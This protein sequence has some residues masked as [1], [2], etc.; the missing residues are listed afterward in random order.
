M[1]TIY[2][3]HHALPN[4]RRSRIMHNHAGPQP[5]G[6]P[7]TGAPPPPP[8]PIIA[9]PPKPKCLPPYSGVDKS[10]LTHYAEYT[11]P[12]FTTLAKPLRR[13]AFAFQT[14]LLDQTTRK[15]DRDVLDVLRLR[16][17]ANNLTS[18]RPDP[19]T[20]AADLQA[21]RRTIRGKGGLGVY[22]ILGARRYPGFAGLAE[23]LLRV[24][25]VKG[26]LER[27]EVGRAWRVV[28]RGYERSERREERTGGQGVGGGCAGD[29]MAGVG[30]DGGL[31]I[32]N[33]GLSGQFGGPPGVQGV[34]VGG[35]NDVTGLDAG[36]EVLASNGG[37][38]TQ[39][40]GQP[41]GQGMNGGLGNVVNG[42][43]TP[44]E[45]MHDQLS[46][47]PVGP[48]SSMPLMSHM[49][50][51]PMYNGGMFDQSNGHPVAQGMG[52]PFGDGMNGYLTPA[53]EA[54]GQMD[55]Q[56]VAPGMATFL[57]SQYPTANGGVV[58]QPGQQSVVSGM[59]A[60]SESHNPMAN[61]GMV[62][63]PERQSVGLDAPLFAGIEDPA[64]DGN[65]A[66]PPS[67]QPFDQGMVA[68][69]GNDMSDP[70]GTSNTGM[71]NLV[72]GQ[73][74]G[75]GAD[76]L[77]YDNT[78]VEEQLPS[79]MMA[80][81]PDFE[82]FACTDYSAYAGSQEVASAATEPAVQEA[83]EEEKAES[84]DLDGMDFEQLMDQRAVL[85]RWGPLQGSIV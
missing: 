49:N 82:T 17:V 11:E 25:V 34:G 73:P 29:W 53:A 2:P 50:G 80:G 40:N 76:F 72:D 58:M 47:Q 57:G 68:S 51:A 70:N 75:P 26:R 30:L 67:Q 27:G 8:P 74:V 19:E 31:L 84:D 12:E 35:G 20:G 81:Q 62:M 55:G 37:M 33:E 21:Y 16:D 39:P 18:V 79:E 5:I 61:S 45:D 28:R 4:I 60:S 22:L 23:E 44:E 56:P 15:N 13:K 83:G 6:Y 71:P 32:G 14:N 9:I 7:I 42:L 63:L 78:Q 1:A 69:A 59:A 85:S 43:P 54:P 66:M 10:F 3:Q 48:G 52:V 77:L 65:M 46:G 41:V 38:F 24:A 64:E 36:N